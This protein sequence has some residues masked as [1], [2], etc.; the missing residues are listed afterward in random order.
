MFSRLG[1]VAFLV[2]VPMLAEASAPQPHIRGTATAI[3]GNSLT[4]KSDDGS[5]RTV[6]LTAATRYVDVLKSSLAAIDKN[7]FIG[8]ATKDVGSK[9]V[10]LEVVVFPEAMRGAGEGHYDWDPLPDT[11]LG[12][13]GKVSSTM[14]NGTVATQTSAGGK[15]NSTMTNGTV[16]SENAAGGARQLTVTYKGGEQQIV[17]PPNVPVVTLAPGSRDHLKVGGALVVTT[18]KDSDNALSVAVGV[19]GATPPM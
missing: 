5:S 16:S 11:T 8:T 9:L 4:I 15:V 17:V 18:A 1:I 10:A 7:S 12:G 6:M 3:D 14:T 13:G 19:D 2:A